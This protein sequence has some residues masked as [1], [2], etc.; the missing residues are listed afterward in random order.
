MKGI[1]FYSL[2]FV[3]VFLGGL[4][5]DGFAQTY[6]TKAIKVVVPFAA[7]GSNDL[8]ARAL[9]KP[10]GKELKQTIVVE[11]I[12]AGTTKVGTLEVIKSEP[13][14]YTLLCVGHSPLMGYYYSGTYDFKVWKKLTVIGQSGEMPYSCVETRV[15][16]PFKTWAELVQH[17]KKNPSKMT[18]GGPGAGGLQNLVAIETAKAAGIEVRYV[19]FAGGGPSGTAVLGGHVDYRICPPSEAITNVR[20]GKTRIL[21]VAYAKRLPEL[22]EVP[23]FKELGLPGE[24]PTLAFDYWGPPDLPQNIVDTFARALEKA[25]QDPEY[26]QFCERIIYYPIFK[27]GPALRQEMKWFEENL[28]SKLAA[29][30]KK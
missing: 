28:G 23:T 6:P 21:G 9:Q 16:S 2:F 30:F 12:P 14:G 8:V 1:R 15:E 29:F 4:P 19:P 27:D 18:V 25:L 11:N 20:A 7:G 10:L 17:A 3:A 24:V 22:P 5:L 13:N 26:R